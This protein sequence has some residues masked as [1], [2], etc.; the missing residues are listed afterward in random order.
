MKRKL[1]PLFLLLAAGI[2]Q[3]QMQTIRGGSF[4]DL[5]GN[6]VVLMGFDGFRETE[7]AKTQCD[8]TGHFV[9]TYPSAYVGAAR[10]EIQGAAPVMVLLNKENFSL[11]WANRQDVNSLTFT[12]SPENEA[13][14]NGIAMNTAAE[15][16]LAGLTY[17]LPQYAKYPKKYRWLEQEIAVQTKQ[18]P[19][20]LLSLRESSYAAYYLKTRKF[21]TDMAQALKKETGQLPEVYE[22]GF[23]TLNFDDNQ[24]W[25]SGLMSDLFAGMYQVAGKDKDSVKAEASINATTD[26]WIK[27]LSA[28]TMKQQEVAEYCFKM[29]EQHYLTRG[30]EYIALSMLDQ[31]GCQLDEKKANLFEQ[32]RKMAV[33]NTA[34]DIV[35]ENGTR[36]STL[37]HAY[38]LVVF[39]ASWCPNCKTDYPALVGIYKKLKAKLDIEVLYVSLDTDAKAYHDFYREAPFITACDTKG[40]AGKV[41]KDYHVF[42][43]PSYFLLNRDLKIVAKL[44]H[45]EELSVL[46]LRS[47]TDYD[48]AQ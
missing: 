35:L 22:T 3:A 37:A 40:W 33:G 5:R 16:K 15:Q 46:R 38:T 28:N 17:L 34:P 29:L 13:F 30:A 41:V 48:V 20:L 10:L 12:G 2:A 39:G 6:G 31:S 36:L 19:D 24:L 14:A 7:L 4:P 42:A 32:Y 26:A 47:V 27:S 21:L 1:I 9:L 25:H 8:S 23:K 44:K 18:F 11:Q 45:P 43:T